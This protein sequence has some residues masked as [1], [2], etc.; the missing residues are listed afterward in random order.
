MTK[1]TFLSQSPL[2]KWILLVTGGSVFFFIVYLL[3]ANID[4]FTDNSWVASILYIVGALINLAIYAGF[5]KLT[6]HRTVHE[7]NIRRSYIDTP[8][9]FAIG[10]VFM[11]VIA[12]ILFCYGYYTP[13]ANDVYFSDVIKCLFLYLLVSV[14]EEVMFR[15]ILHRM[16]SERF[17]LTAA[18]IV[19]SL[20]FGFAHITNDNATIIAAVDIAIEAGLLLGAAYELSRNLWLPIGIH[21][22][23]NFTQGNIYG[24]NVSGNYDEVSVFCSEISGPDII[25]GGEFGPE[26]SVI[27]AIFGLGLSALLL[28]IKKKD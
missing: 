27:T 18:L 15:G 7:L 21:W 28:Y 23:W 1:T 2:W 11:S 19:S 14:G 16:I 26:A 22:A 20:L 24:F 12:A 4:L 10:A 6:E 8:I 13:Y 25:T 5:V 9:G 17:G 3:V